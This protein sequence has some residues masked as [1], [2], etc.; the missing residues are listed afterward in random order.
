VSLPLSLALCAD[1]EDYPQLAQFMKAR[2]REEKRKEEGFLQTM[3]FYFFLELRLALITM[4]L[5]PFDSKPS[6][7]PP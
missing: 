2:R 5:I 6:S 3:I 4:I 1:N 7:P